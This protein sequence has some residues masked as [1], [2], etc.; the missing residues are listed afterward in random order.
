M[1]NREELSE[2]CIPEKKETGQES[3]VRSCKI[4]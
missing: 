2:K 4:Y 3:K 1:K